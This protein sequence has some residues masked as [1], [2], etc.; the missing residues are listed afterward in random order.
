[1]IAYIRNGLDCKVK[2][3]KIEKYDIMWF[4]FDKN[5]FSTEHDVILFF[6][7]TYQTVHYIAT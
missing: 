4:S 6:V 5:L 2:M 1:M 3:L 7:T